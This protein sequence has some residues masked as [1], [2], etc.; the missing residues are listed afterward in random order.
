[1]NTTNS[2]FILLALAVIIPT[3]IV[4]SSGKKNAEQSLAEIHAQPADERPEHEIVD[5]HT[6]G[7]AWALATFIAIVLC[8]AALHGNV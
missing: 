5:N 1:M 4:L 3:W 6:S 2:G 7:G 8:L